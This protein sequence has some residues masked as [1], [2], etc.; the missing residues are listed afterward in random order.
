MIMKRCFDILYLGK[1]YIFN[2][3]KFIH[4]L[5]KLRK[6]ASSLHDPFLKVPTRNEL[7]GKTDLLSLETDNLSLHA[8]PSLIE[9]SII[10]SQ[11]ILSQPHLSLQFKS[12]QVL[13]VSNNQKLDMDEK[14]GKNRLYYSAGFFFPNKLN[15]S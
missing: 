8:D 14:K 12:T 3:E 6:R 13:F 10:N 15:I 11:C 2:L 7:F 1:W 4:F 9:F 5:W